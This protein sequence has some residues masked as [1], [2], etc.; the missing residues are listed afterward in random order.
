MIEKD[1]E[2]E[3]DLKETLT[4]QKAG[5]PIGPIILG[6]GM[7][8]NGRRR[9]GHTTPQDGTGI[10]NGTNPTWTPLPSQPCKGPQEQPLLVSK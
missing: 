10:Q 1:L 5:T 4:W 2:H 9:S 8:S 7:G 6:P 3:K